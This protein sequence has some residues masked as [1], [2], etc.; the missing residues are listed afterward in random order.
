MKRPKI[1][2]IV[3]VYNVEEYLDD[4]LKSILGQSYREFE[5][6]LVNDGSTDDSPKICE[7]YSQEHPDVIKVINKKNE[8]LN[9]ARRDGF[10]AS[11]GSFITFVDS[12]DL[13]HKNYLELLL[14]PLLSSNVDVSVG[15]F[16]QFKTSADIHDIRGD[17]DPIVERNKK[18]FMNW[19][20]KGDGSFSDGVFMVTAW[21][22]LFKRQLIGS[23]DWDLSN[24]R[25][26]EDEFW[27]MQVF[28][29]ANKGVAVTSS[30]LYCY[31]VNPN[32]ITQKTYTNTFNGRKLNKFE[33]IEELYQKS[34]KYLGEDYENELLWRFA[35]QTIVFIDRYVD[36]RI[37]KHGD[38][39]SI[40]TYLYPKIN[41]ILKLD[42]PRS[43]EQK[44]LSIN[45]YGIVL[46][47]LSIK[48]SLTTAAIRGIGKTK[49][50]R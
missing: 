13:V 29:A 18:K 1:S 20:I 22:K 6:I 30:P 42:L 16:Q 27:S 25:S 7:R 9:Y 41:L 37:L 21:G 11:K 8:G 35:V 38:I 10:A 12:D 50:I 5:V 19:F 3:P 34:L 15:G 45:R 32:S 44:I 48:L 40:R 47:V 28:H 49:S 23:I 33:F 14:K 17:D 26:N 4:C 24:Y 2:I 46:Y 39:M 31:R 36:S 43:I